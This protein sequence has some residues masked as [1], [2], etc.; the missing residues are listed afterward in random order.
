[1]ALALTEIYSSTLTNVSFVEEDRVL[2]ERGLQSNHNWSLGSG[3]EPRWGLKG[4]RPTIFSFLMS[5][6]QVNGLQWH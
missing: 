6:R 5:L 1:M 2:L 4:Q 3:A